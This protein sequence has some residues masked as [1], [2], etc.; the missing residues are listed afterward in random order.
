MSKSVSDNRQATAATVLLSAKGT[1]ESIVIAFILAFIFRA[2]LAEAYRIPTGSMAPTLFGAHQ[3]RM[4]D[5]CGYQ[6]TYAIIEGP[7][8]PRTNVCPNCRGA[9]DALPMRQGRRWIID[10]GD[11]ILVLKLGYEL[12]YLFPSLSERFGPK[13]W[14][15]VVFKNPADPK[16]NFIKRLIGL[17]GETIEIID[18]NVYV[19][20]KIARKTDVAQKSLWFAVHDSDYLPLRKNT[21]G[22]GGVPGWRPRAQADRIVWDTSGRV[23]TF[24]G[25]E[26]NRSGTIVF[27]GPITDFYAYDDPDQPMHDSIAVSDLKLEF[28]MNIV[29]GPGTIELA[30]SKRTDLF[31]AR[32]ET[33]GSVS[34]LRSHLGKGL[35]GNNVAEVIASNQIPPLP[36]NTPVTVSFEN[37]DYSVVLTINGKRVLATDQQQYHGDLDRLRKLTP[38]DVRPGPIVQITASGLDCQLRHIKLY[39]DIYYQ[40]LRM[41]EE[42]NPQTGETNHLHAR[43]G[44]GVTGN[45]I[46]LGPED[47][48]VLG[49]NSPQSKDSRLWWEVGPHLRP[50]LEAGEYQLG[51]VPR[52]QLVGKAVFVYWPAA[53]RIFST[54]PGIIPNVGQM[55]FVR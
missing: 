37:V 24:S 1:I 55:R 21:L 16:I 30:M 53:L 18:G 9:S 32:I 5:N 7:R 38:E 34:L 20:N 17:P 25:R 49:D 35:S 41:G 44:H 52:N 2:F 4:C 28:L 11:R 22:P 31:R 15:V 36:D 39:R 6:Y 26:T 50:Q 48:Y 47:Y 33:A 45:P 12:A 13:R 29:G 10:S 43:L 23:A 19:D 40:S 14:D 46:R 8:G 54:G 3:S 51:T 27:N 42:K